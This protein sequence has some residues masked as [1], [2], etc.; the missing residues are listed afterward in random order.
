MLNFQISQYKTKPFGN[1]LF[2]QAK[3][4]YFRAVHPLVQAGSRR[5]ALNGSFQN[6]YRARKQAVSGLVYASLVA[7]TGCATSA[8]IESLRAEV[9]MANAVAARAEAS[10]SNTQRQLAALKKA[11]EPLEPVSETTAPPATNS[12]D[13][14]GYKWGRLR[15]D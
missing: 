9:A 13:P 3:T 5:Q 14:S 10:V 12:P 4:S 11:S 6:V 15:Q 7:L 1:Q 8:E 2:I